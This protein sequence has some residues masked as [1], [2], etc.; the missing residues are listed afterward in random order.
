MSPCPLA[1]TLDCHA[2]SGLLCLQRMS[3]RAI[4]IPGRAGAVHIERDDAGVPHITASQIDDA[5][6]G[7]GFCHA[8]DRGLQMLLVR[9]LGRGQMCELLRD[10]EESFAL[11]RF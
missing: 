4:S 10:A 9:T 7:L 1:L 3:E 8:R 6:F 5:H 11:D 2:W